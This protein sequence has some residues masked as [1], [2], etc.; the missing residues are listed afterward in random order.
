MAVYLSIEQYKML[1]T[2][3]ASYINDIELKPATQGWIG[4]QLEHE[5]ARLDASLRKRYQVPYAT[6]ADVPLIV[7][8]WLAKIMDVAVLLKR[9]VSATDEQ[10]QE[11]KARALDAVTEI[12]AAANAE[13]GLL[14][15][16]LSASGAAGGGSA[17]IAGGP[18]S[19]S[20]QSPYVWIDGQAEIGRQENTSRGGTRT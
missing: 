12:Q 18:R 1:S 13:T 15:L 2:L 20:E 10:F 9:G 4:A 7:Q 6:E 17:V 19:Y 3:P 5:T 8:G 14:E 16:P 11:Y